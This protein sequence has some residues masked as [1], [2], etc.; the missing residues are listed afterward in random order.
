MPIKSSMFLE[1]SLGVFRASCHIVGEQMIASFVCDDVRSQTPIVRMHSGCIF[2]DA[3][4]SLHCDCGQQKDAAMEAIKRHGR[5][6]FLY[7]P[8]QEGRG[9]GL[10]VK[11]AEMAIQ[12][13]KSLDTIEAFR[14]MGLEPDIRTYEGEIAVL[15]ELEI[16]TN[17]IHF[18]GN[19]NKRAALEQAGYV[20]EDEIE[21]TAPLGQLAADERRLKQKNLGYAYRD[22]Q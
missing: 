1:T 8:F 2:G 14:S 6:V 15:K 9:H 22:E 3:F 16:P 5:G 4:H 17:I 21:W 20:I 19:P 7:S 12:R 13:A 10:E 11:I 18:S